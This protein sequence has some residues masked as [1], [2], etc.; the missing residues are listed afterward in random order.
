M[1][2]N[3]Y[4]NIKIYPYEL[5]CWLHTNDITEV[6]RNQVQLW[7]EHRVWVLIIKNPVFRKQNYTQKESTLQFIT[8]WIEW[9]LPLVSRVEAVPP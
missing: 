5:F 3:R 8:D 9:P 1:Y 7:S 4:S 6:E 2:D